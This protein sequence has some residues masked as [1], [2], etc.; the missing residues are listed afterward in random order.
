LVVR[1]RER[2]QASRDRVVAARL[3]LD[4]VGRVHVHEVHGHAYEQSVHVRA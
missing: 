1:A 3:D 2:R 4:V